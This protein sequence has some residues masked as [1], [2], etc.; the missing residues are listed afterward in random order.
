MAIFNAQGGLTF[1]NMPVL[2][3]EKHSDIPFDVL[4]VA[5]FDHPAALIWELEVKGIP[6]D[7]LV[8]LRDA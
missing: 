5:T 1:L 8:L 2:P 4:I 6:R 3:I 7:K